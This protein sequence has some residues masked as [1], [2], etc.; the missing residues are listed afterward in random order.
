MYLKIAS[1]EEKQEKKKSFIGYYNSLQKKQTTKILQ[2]Y[3]K[4]KK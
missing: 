2:Q 3:I 1:P 4:D